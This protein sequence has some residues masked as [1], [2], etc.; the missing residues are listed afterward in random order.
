M[1]E[2]KKQQQID[3]ASGRYQQTDGIDASKFWII[4]LILTIWPIWKTW[5]IFEALLSHDSEPQQNG[6]PADTKPSGQSGTRA[7][8]SGVYI[9][10]RQRCED[11]HSSSSAFLMVGAQPCLPLSAG[12]GLSVFR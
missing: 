10:S 6:I 1:R 7:A 8:S 2:K 4:W 3:A 9:S 12:P 5:R 11:L